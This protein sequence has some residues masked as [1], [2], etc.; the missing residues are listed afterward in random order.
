LY[1]YV[2]I[3]YND[4]YVKRNF[5]SSDNS[6]KSFNNMWQNCMNDSSYLVG[7]NNYDSVWKIE[8]PKVEYLYN[9]CD[10]M[11]THVNPCTNIEH[12]PDKYKKNISNTFF[13]FEGEKYL[14]NGTMKY[15]IFGHTHDYREFEEFGVKCISNPLGYP[16]EREDE[17]KVKRIEIG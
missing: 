8:E 3:A 5:P 15:W 2:N 4:G 17:V 6:P 16:D 7:I 12:I 13:T 14:K 11:I 1:L 10:V 9:K